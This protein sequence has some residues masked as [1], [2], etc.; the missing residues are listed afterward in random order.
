MKPRNFRRP[1]GSPY[2]VVLQVFSCKF[3]GMYD[4]RSKADRQRKKNSGRLMRWRI[5]ASFA[6]NHS[7]AIPET[8]RIRELKVMWRAKMLRVHIVTSG[9][10]KRAIL[11]SSS[12]NELFSLALYGNPDCLHARA[13]ARAYIS[14]ICRRTNSPHMLRP[15]TG[16]CQC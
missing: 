2:A 14:N 10:T 12:M 9:K 15:R 4:C 6:P 5:R 1:Q 3:H 8:F 16:L 11:S 7:G 13:P